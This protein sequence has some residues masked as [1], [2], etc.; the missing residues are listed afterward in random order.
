MNRREF[1]ASTS[2][3]AAA[4][5]LPAWAQPLAAGNSSFPENVLRESPYVEHDPIEGYHNAPPS[6]SEA[7]QDMKFGARHPLGDL[8]HLASRKRVGALSENVHGRPA[9]L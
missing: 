4:S 8:F 6:A 2:A 3:L 5:A 1:L 7:F 9:G